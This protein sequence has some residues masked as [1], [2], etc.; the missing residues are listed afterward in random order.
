MHHRTPVTKETLQRLLGY[1]ILNWPGSYLCALTHKSAAGGLVPQSAPESYEKLEFLGDSILNFIVGRWLYETHAH[2]PT[3]NE[4]YLTQMRTKLVSGKALSTI[5][6]RMGLQHVVIMSDKALSSGF[7]TNPRILEDV[8]EALIGAC[9]LDV[10]LVGARQFVLSFINTYVDQSMLVHTNFKDT[11]MQY[12]QAQGKDV[13]LPEYTSTKVG[14]TFHTTAKACG[15]TGH[16]R[17][18]VKKEAQQIAAQDC[19][20]VLGALKK[21]TTSS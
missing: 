15:A 8:L 1:Q 16:G 10:G 11:L 13:P 7:N 5:A 9:Y 19:L 18:R 3:I 6:H 21:N 20:G 4:G 2:S 12:C 17:A 14:D